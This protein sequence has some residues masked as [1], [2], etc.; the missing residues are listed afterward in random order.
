MGKLHVFS[1]PAALI[2]LLALGACE[3][4]VGEDAEV[5]GGGGVPAADRRTGWYGFPI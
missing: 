1:V 4:P 5:P 2:A 3:K